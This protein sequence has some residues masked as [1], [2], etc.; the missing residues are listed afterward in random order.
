MKFDNDWTGFKNAMEFEKSFEAD[1][2]SKKEWKA[3]RELP[4]PSIYRWLAR[5]DDYDSEGPTGEY[6]RKTGE[7]KTISNL[8]QEA[9]QD[10]NKI[11]ANLASEIDLKN[12]NLDELQYKCNEK[13]MSCIE[14]DA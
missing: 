5:S 10:S 9:T 4:S 11:L 13:T 1:H 8:V 7:L 14:Q 6:L 12:Q 3:H 2:Q